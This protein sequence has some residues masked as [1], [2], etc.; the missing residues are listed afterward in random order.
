MKGYFLKNPQ[1]H[2]SK[3]EFASPKLTSL[4]QRCFEMEVS[5][6]EAKESSHGWGFM[7]EE[8]KENKSQYR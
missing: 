5:F 2:E 8:K 1:P 3:E 4:P 6:G 7:K